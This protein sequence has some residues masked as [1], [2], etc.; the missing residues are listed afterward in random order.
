TNNPGN[1]GAT[2]E[3]EFHLA[4][5]ITGNSGSTVHATAIAAW[6]PVASATTIPLIFSQCELEEMGGS[7]NPPTAPSDGAEVIIYFH[8]S[9]Q[10]GE[11][12]SGPSGFDDP[13]SGGFGWLENSG[14]EVT[15]DAGGWVADEPGN[16]VPNGCNPS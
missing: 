2:D 11:C 5:I 14:C 16:G 7:I 10:V 1:S 9:N 4:Q 6:G 13:I 3:V 12:P 15:I 8:G